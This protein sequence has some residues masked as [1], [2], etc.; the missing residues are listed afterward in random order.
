MTSQQAKEKKSILETYILNTNNFSP[1]SSSTDATQRGRNSSHL[2]SG[3]YQLWLLCCFLWFMITLLGIHYTTTHT[4][5]LNQLLPLTTLLWK[6]VFHLNFSKLYLPCH[7]SHPILR[8]WFCSL[9]GLVWKPIPRVL[10][11]HEKY[12]PRLSFIK[13]IITL[14]AF[15]N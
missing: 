13:Q 12:I 14:K 4:Y 10:K 15:C 8:L 11:S 5:H 9:L 3:D 1:H 2:A 7:T 6:P